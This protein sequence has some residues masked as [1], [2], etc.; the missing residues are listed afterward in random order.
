VNCRPND[1]AAV[2]AGLPECDIGKV[3]KVLKSCM[4]NDKA[5]WSYE[6]AICFTENGSTAD[7]IADGLLRPIRDNDGEDETLTWAGKPKKV[8]VDELANRA[9]QLYRESYKR[10]A[11]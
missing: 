11:R 7:Y 4:V 2:V 8:T 9:L 10:V 6:G 3:V 5:Y 1:L